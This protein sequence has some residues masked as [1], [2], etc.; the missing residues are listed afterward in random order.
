[1]FLERIFIPGAAVSVTQFN[2][3]F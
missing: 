2:V 1:M 3:L